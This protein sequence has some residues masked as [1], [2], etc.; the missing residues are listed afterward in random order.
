MVVSASEINKYGC[1]HCGY[2]SGSVGFRFN[3]TAHWQCGECHKVSLALTDG[4]E[5]AE[6]GWPE[7][8]TMKRQ[9]HPRKGKPK[10]GNPDKKPEGGGEFFW[11]RGIGMDRTPGCFICGGEEKTT[12]KTNLTAFK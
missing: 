9:E 1:P 3:N 11:V 6:T 12:A 7:R 10:H 4:I 5:E 8:P 2:R